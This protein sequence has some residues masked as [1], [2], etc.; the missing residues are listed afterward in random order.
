[1]LKQRWFN[2][3]HGGKNKNSAG[4]TIVR[5]AVVRRESSRN[6]FP[7]FASVREA[8]MVGKVHWNFHRK[9]TGILPTLLHF[10]KVYKYVAISV[11]KR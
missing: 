3:K 2:W 10:V 11:T 4:Q 8:K 5:R 9:F 7:S 6:N 1:M